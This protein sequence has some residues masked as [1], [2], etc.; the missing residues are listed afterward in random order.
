MYLRPDHVGV[1]IKRPDGLFLLE[2]ATNGM[3]LRPLHERLARSN[4]YDVAV[5]RLLCDRTAT[6]AQITE[7]FIKDIIDRPYKTNLI[8]L[9]NASVENRTKAMADQLGRQLQNTMD[10][11][12][13]I[14]FELQSQSLTDAQRH[15]LQQEKGRLLEHEVL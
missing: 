9:F 7:D 14:T 5:R 11:L 4:S 6:T 1:V 10:Q 8:T 15:A 12:E 3:K 13:Q 2:A